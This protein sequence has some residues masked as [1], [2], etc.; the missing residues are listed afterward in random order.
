MYK[1]IQTYLL[2]LLFVMIVGSIIHTA[3]GNAVLPDNLYATQHYEEMVNRL[4]DI[5]DAVHN[6]ID[7]IWYYEQK[8]RKSLQGGEY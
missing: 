8:Q 1:K 5:R 4:H 7:E 2:P 3:N 6:R